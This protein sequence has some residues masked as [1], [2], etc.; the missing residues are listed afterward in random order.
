[1]KRE[2]AIEI[3][4]E[5]SSKFNQT[6]T[7]QWKMNLSIWTLLVFAIFYKEQMSLSVCGCFCERCACLIEEIIGII[8]IVIHGAFCYFIQRSLDFDKKF[9]D[10]IVD[11]LNKSDSNTLTLADIKEVKEE[12]KKES[13]KPTVH[14][15]ILQLSL[16]TVLVIVFWLSN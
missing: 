3:Y 5:R 13:N 6:R 10:L 9:N 14:W 4:K 15:M 2:E 11:K 12:I 8:V 16:T 1:M 7:I